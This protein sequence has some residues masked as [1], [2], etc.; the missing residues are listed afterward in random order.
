MT[1]NKRLK[2][3]R[4]LMPYD[5]SDAFDNPEIKNIWDDIDRILNKHD[6][7]AKFLVNDKIKKTGN[8]SV[9]MSRKEK[10]KFLNKRI[11]EIGPI[12]KRSYFEEGEI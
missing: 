2:M 9:A 7:E 5:H 11:K 4:L 12:S 8:K 1:E 6:K 10:I 3:I